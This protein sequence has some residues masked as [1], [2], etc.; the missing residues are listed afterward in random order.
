MLD[1]LRNF[2]RSLLHEKTMGD[3]NRTNIHKVILV[4]S[5][6]LIN[7]EFKFWDILDG[8]I[9]EIFQYSLSC[10]SLFIEELNL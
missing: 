2:H 8:E 5:I 4:T 3:H 10:Y 9:H 6:A 1:G 7:S